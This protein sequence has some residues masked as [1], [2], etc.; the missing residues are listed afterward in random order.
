VQTRLAGQQGDTQRS[1]LY[2]AQQFQ[3]EAL[4]H[5]GQVHLWKIHHQK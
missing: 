4:A 3:A 1:S 5:L 2:P